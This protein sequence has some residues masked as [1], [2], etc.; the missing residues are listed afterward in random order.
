T[1]QPVIQMLLEH[2]ALEPLALPFS[3]IG[4]LNRK[5]RKVD[6]LVRRESVVDVRELSRKYPQRPTIADNVMH[7]QQQPVSVV[8]EA[9]QHCAQRIIAAQIKRAPSF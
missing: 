4:I 2:L 1:L 3:K 5:L 8:V 9:H 7:G 6:I